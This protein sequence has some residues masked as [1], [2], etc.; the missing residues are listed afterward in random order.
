[1]E[2]ARTRM[3]EKSLPL[4]NNLHCLFLCI[5]QRT[6]ASLVSFTQGNS[7][8]GF[9]QCYLEHVWSF[10]IENLATIAVPSSSV[11]FT[12]LFYFPMTTNQ[13]ICV[14]LDDLKKLGPGFVWESATYQ[15][16]EDFSYFTQLKMKK[17]PSKI[18]NKLPCKIPQ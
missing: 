9:L 6:L 3:E 14:I 18:L 17:K 1:M 12:S 13:D 15:L 10:I 2:V 16:N 5:R 8:E 7:F 4:L 11:F